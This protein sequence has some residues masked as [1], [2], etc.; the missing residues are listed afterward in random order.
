MFEGSIKSKFLM[1][2]VITPWQ[3]G[4][5][6]SLGIGARTQVDLQSLILQ[7]GPDLNTLMMYNGDGTAHVSIYLDGKFFMRMGPLGTFGFD[8]ESLMRF[9]QIELTASANIATDTFV[10][11]VGNTGPNVIGV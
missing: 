4:G 8:W 9:A 10:L 7:Y 1:P 11:S 3:T 6:T 2:T 5:D